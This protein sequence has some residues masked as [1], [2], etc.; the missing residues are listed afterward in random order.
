MVDLSD[1]RTP[2]WPELQLDGHVSRLRISLAA[3]FVSLVLFW[4]Y[5]AGSSLGR[6]ETV[7]VPFFYAALA[8]YL[9][10]VWSAYKI[11]QVLYDSGPYKHGGWHVWIGSLLLNPVALGWLIPVSVLIAAAGM[12]RKL[13]A[14]WPNG[15]VA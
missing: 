5:V 14:R 6:L 7:L 9:C 11:Q 3:Y 12:R 15:R 2:T 4:M 1:P 13:E 8:N 10:L